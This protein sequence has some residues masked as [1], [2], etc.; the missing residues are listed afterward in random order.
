MCVPERGFLGF[1]YSMT[2]CDI[3]L[4]CKFCP[5]FMFTSG[6]NDRN[7]EDY[8]HVKAVCSP[9]TDLW[10]KKQTLVH[11]AG[12]VSCR[13]KW[14]TTWELIVCVW[15]VTKCQISATACLLGSW[16]ETRKQHKLSD[17]SKSKACLMREQSDWT[18][19]WQNV[20]IT[21]NHLTNG[22]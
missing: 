4:W 5:F 13:K 20:L 8:V 9:G 10:N 1:H 15:R 3:C 21:L 6:N 7:V 2:H 19:G 16:K 22:I 14:K 17:G 12:L 11:Q 18:K